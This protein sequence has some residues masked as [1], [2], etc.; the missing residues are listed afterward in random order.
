MQQETKTQVPHEE[1]DVMDM[2]CLDKIKVE[3]MIYIQRKV[4]G[5]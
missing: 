2:V 1:N 5:S 3:V 4:S